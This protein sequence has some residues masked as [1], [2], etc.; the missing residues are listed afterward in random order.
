MTAGLWFEVLG[1]AVALGCDAFAVGL[2]VGARWRGPRQVFRLSFHFGLFQFGMPLLGW[3][4]G[5]GALGLIALWAPWLAFAVLVFL[6]LRMAWEGYKGD[7]P[8]PGGADPTRGLSLIGLSVAT[9]IDALGAGFSLGLVG[10]QIFGAALIIGVTAAL[11]TLGAMK[12]SG[13]VSRR[14]GRV[15]SVAGGIILM[16]IGVKIV[17]G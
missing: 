12:L 17:L 3:L 11:M 16:G 15:M 4:L 13:L 10:G 9:S 8:G 2:G 1:L 5:R 14:W 7:E 6:G